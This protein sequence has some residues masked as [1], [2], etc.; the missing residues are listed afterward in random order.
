[1]H[2]EATD[3]FNNIKQKFKTGSKYA[4]TYGVGVGS[5]VALHKCWLTKW[6]LKNKISSLFKLAYIINP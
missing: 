4:I 2:K 3:D 1:M 6:S 5:G